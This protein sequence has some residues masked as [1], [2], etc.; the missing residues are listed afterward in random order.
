MELLL[1]VVPNVERFVCQYGKVR[2]HNISNPDLKLLFKTRGSSLR[3]LSLNP[4]P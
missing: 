3:E 2:A 4:S 1:S